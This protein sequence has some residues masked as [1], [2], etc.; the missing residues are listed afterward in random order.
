MI[1]F[2]LSSHPVKK[3][4]PNSPGRLKST[5]QSSLTPAVDPLGKKKNAA[6]IFV[7]RSSGSQEKKSTRK[8]GGFFFKM[9][10]LSGYLKHGVVLIF[11]RCPSTF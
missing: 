11:W 6:G 10:F 2:F 4:P 5:S 3:K 9:F 1:Y 8:T 7:V